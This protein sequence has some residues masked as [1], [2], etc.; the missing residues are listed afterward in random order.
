MT[1]FD[2]LTREQQNCLQK[3]WFKVPSS[4]I[5]CPRLNYSHRFAKSTTIGRWSLNPPR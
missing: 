2:F 4:K 1:F 5:G 3:G